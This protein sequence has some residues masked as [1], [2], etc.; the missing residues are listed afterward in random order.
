[1]TN[2]TLE[3]KLE[4]SRRD[5]AG[6]TRHLRDLNAGLKNGGHTSR[7][8]LATEEE[9]LLAKMEVVIRRKALC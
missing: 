2:F 9:I 6:E 7:A 3:E 4:I 5:C 8:R 1:M